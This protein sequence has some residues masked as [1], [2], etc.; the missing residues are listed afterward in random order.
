MTLLALRDGVLPPTI[1]LH[2][3]DPSCALNHI[4]SARRVSRHRTALKISLGFGGHLAA[5]VVRQ[6]D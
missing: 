4:A 1:N 5:V 3:P 6:G 2:E